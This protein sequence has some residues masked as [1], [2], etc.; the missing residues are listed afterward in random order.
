MLGPMNRRQ[1]RELLRLRAL[2][3]RAYHYTDTHTDPALEDELQREVLRLRA[4][5]IGR[6]YR[7]RHGPAATPAQPTL[8]PCTRE[9]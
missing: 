7:E 8:S 4:L 3:R 9:S 5:A 6:A 1:R 2:L